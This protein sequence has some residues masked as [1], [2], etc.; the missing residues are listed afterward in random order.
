MCYSTYTCWSSKR[1]RMRT[2]QCTYILQYLAATLALGSFNTRHTIPDADKLEISKPVVIEPTTTFWICFLTKPIARGLTVL[3]K[4]L[5][6]ELRMENLR[7]SILTM[8]LLT[9]D[10]F[11]SAE[12]RWT[13]AVRPSPPRTTSPN[14]SWSS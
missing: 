3:Y 13:V 12:T 11:L 14:Q 1:T 9:D 6:F 7:V 10:L 5:S 4:K 8:T 2:G